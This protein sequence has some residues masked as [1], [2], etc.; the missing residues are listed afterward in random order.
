MKYYLYVSDSKV[1]MFIPQMADDRKKKIAIDFKIDLKLLSA[2]WKSEKEA[3]NERIQRL[4]AVSS[5]IRN[6]GNIGTT[7][8]PDE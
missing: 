7:D 4:E 8:N 6:W 3:V 2:S 1:D 5:F